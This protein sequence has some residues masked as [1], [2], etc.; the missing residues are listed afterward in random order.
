MG[1][2]RIRTITAESLEEA[3]SAISRGDLIVVPTDTVYGVA[4]DPFNSEAIDR[5][6]EVKRRPRTK[7]IQVLF[8]DL[9]PLESLGLS[10][11]HPLEV[12]SATFLPG[13]FSPICDAVP[14][15]RLATLRHDARPDGSEKLTQGIRV[16]DFAPL[17]DILAALGPLAATS[18]NIS[19]QESATSAQEA[20]AALGDDVA[21]YFDAGTTPGPVSSTVVAAAPEKTDGIDILREGVIPARV[22]RAALHADTA[23][24]AGSSTISSAHADR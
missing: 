6:F 9:S 18:A 22:I 14:A 17:H 5:L 13:G 2:E 12:L 20:Y 21:V 3:R 19:G 10:L 23:R 11:P 24:K 7:S 1:S 4:C 8:P 16:P 15:S